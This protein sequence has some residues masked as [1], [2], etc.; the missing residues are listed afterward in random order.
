MNLKHLLAVHIESV[1]LSRPVINLEIFAVRRN[2]ASHC[3]NLENNLNRPADAAQI[4]VP[5]SRE[6]SAL[7]IGYSVSRIAFGAFVN[8]LFSGYR[9]FSGTCLRE[10]KGIET[11][12]RSASS[13]IRKFSDLISLAY[14]GALPLR[15]LVEIIIY[16]TV[17]I[18]RSQQSG[19]QN[20]GGIAAVVALN[21][22][23]LSGIHVTHCKFPV[24]ARAGIYAMF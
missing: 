18:N 9:N 21:H 22:V 8:N 24:A 6:R 5:V 15:P 7:L 19:R 16:K 2:Q 17:R 4:H 10:R 3:V 20:S 14:C 1:E 23:V 11:L 12:N 13:S